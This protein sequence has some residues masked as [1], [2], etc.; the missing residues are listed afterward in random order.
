MIS[1]SPYLPSSNLTFSV[2]KTI[3]GGLETQELYKDSILHTHF[4]DR[5]K[6]AKAELTQHPETSQA[7]RPFVDSFCL[8][9]GDENNIENINNFLTLVLAQCNL[10]DAHYS[11][12]KEGYKYL[13]EVL[14]IQDN[15]INKRDIHGSSEMRLQAL[16]GDFRAISLDDCRP[17]AAHGIRMI[18]VRGIF[19]KQL[20]NQWFSKET[21][22]PVQDVLD[23]LSYQMTK[24]A[25][26]GPLPESI[27]ALKFEKAEDLANFSANFRYPVPDLFHQ[28]RT[29]YLSK[30]NELEQH[31][32]NTKVLAHE[33]K[34]KRVPEDKINQCIQ[35][36]SRP[37]SQMSK[38]ALVLAKVSR[39]F[40]EK[41]LGSYLQ[42]ALI[43]LLK[44]EEQELTPGLPDDTAIARA[45]ERATEMING[46][47]S[48]PNSV[49]PAIAAAKELIKSLT[50]LPEDRTTFV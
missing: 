31:F 34:T 30:C 41:D 46:C 1:T 32:T 15:L 25:I 4:E 3:D 50:P 45:L 20:V 27:K 47:F 44:T 6:R 11:I 7:L 13:A 37:V 23:L 14:K 12:S 9:Q 36:L 43:L 22:Q 49:F 42:S 26:L 18:D 29:N 21:R 17:T 2:I 10:V 35:A 16:E 39:T 38:E 28:Y 33:L 5:L 48:G 24:G 40:L 8:F 19:V